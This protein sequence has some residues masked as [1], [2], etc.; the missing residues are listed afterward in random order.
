MVAVPLKR[1]VGNPGGPRNWTIGIGPKVQCQ[2]IH[3]DVGV[4][5]RGL[6]ASVAEHLL[7]RAQVGAAREQ[8]GC[9]RMT[10]AVR[11]EIISLEHVLAP[12]LHEGLHGADS[13]AA[14]AI[15]RLA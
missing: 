12:L 11:S 3:R 6:K 5:L 13:D 14:P 2:M 15:T 10:K 9:E 1:C 4:A 7:D 8:C